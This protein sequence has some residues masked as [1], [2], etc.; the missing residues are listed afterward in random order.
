[1]FAP[2]NTVSTDRQVNNSNSGTVETPTTS[3]ERMEN[4]EII[5]DESESERSDQEESLMAIDQ[6]LAEAQTTR[7]HMTRSGAAKQSAAARSRSNSF[8]KTIK[9]DIIELIA[10]TNDN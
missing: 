9:S 10:K 7:R 4:D 8:K 6:S 2:N 5:L 3:T 1:V